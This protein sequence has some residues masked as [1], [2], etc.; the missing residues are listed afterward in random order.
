M[1][2]LLRMRKISYITRGGR[3]FNWAVILR[4]MRMSSFVLHS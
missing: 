1:D 2:A 3:S 4:R